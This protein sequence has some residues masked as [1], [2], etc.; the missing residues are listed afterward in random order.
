MSYRPGTDFEC[1]ECGYEWEAWQSYAATREQPA[2]YEPSDCPAC[3]TNRK[4]PTKCAEC[5]CIHDWRELV[6]FRE[7]D[8]KD[9]ERVCLACF[10][11]EFA[12]N[13][14]DHP[15]HQRRHELETAQ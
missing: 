11:T 1:D 13:Y 12:E 5:D 8:L 9:N 6:S 2:E 10:F 4:L 3:D 7:Y 14:P 15:A